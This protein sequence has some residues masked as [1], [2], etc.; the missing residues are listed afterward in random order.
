MCQALLGSR[1]SVIDQMNT[2]LFRDCVVV[3]KTDNKV[4]K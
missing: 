3:E 4:N 2:V 1:D